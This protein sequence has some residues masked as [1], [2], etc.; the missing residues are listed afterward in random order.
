MARTVV[1]IVYNHFPEIARKMPVACGRIVQETLFEIETFAKIVVP[2][3]T[4]ALR[5][6]I[7]TEMDSQ[8]S[9]SVFTNQEYAHFVELGT[10]KMPARPYMTPAAEQ[11]RPK[12]M[13][14]M[15]DLESRLA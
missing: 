13:S 7:Q 10:S 5:A 11:A 4:G 6:S 2:V 1:E 14:K 8:T 15:Q 3:D 9:G 12:F